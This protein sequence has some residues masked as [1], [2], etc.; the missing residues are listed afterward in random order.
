MYNRL[1]SLEDIRVVN[2]PKAVKEVNSMVGMINSNNLE[3][4]KVLKV[5]DKQMELIRVEDKVDTGKHKVGMV[6]LKAAINLKVGI[7]VDMGEVI[8]NSKV[9]EGTNNKVDMDNKDFH[10]NSIINMVE[11][12]QVAYYLSQALRNNLNMATLPSHKCMDLQ[13]RKIYRKMFRLVKYL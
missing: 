3:D 11:C 4:I 8:S 13:N 5:T 2:S 12:N 10:T 9:M 7:K 6:S 1:N